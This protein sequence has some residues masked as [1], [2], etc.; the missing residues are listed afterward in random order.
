M[1]LQKGK[2]EKI[3]TLTKRCY[4][5]VKG[6]LHKC[7]QRDGSQLSI[8][9]HLAKPAKFKETNTFRHEILTY[10]IRML[11]RIWHVNM[12]SN[13]R[14]SPLSLDPVLFDE[15]TK[16]PLQTIQRDASSCYRM[17]IM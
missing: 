14:L 5:Q 9:E 11:K 13:C 6:R 12:S 16:I 17:S 8:A 3:I 2:A 10:N 7:K 4:G 15:R 1:Q